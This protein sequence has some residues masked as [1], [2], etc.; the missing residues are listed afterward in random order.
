MALPSVLVAVVRE[1]LA[2][3]RPSDP[4]DLIFKGPKRRCGETTS[5]DQRGGPNA[6]PRPDCPRA[7]G[8]ERELRSLTPCHAACYFSGDCI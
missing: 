6:W 7:F 5:I 8:S 2:E 3:F 1:H 4:D